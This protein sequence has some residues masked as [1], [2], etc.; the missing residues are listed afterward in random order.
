MSEGKL[1]DLVRDLDLPKEAAELLGSRLQEDHFLAP[2]TTFSWYRNRE[3]KFLLF[4][5]QTATLVYYTDVPKL[6]KTLGLNDCNA[7]E[8][9][10]F[11]DSSKRNLKAVLLSNGNSH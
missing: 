5:E 8:F 2:N 11:I 6:M 4:F 3:D 1:N 10:L 9:R 7:D